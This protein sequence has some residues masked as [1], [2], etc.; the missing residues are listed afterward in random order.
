MTVWLTHYHIQ[1]GDIMRHIELLMTTYDH[2]R[3]SIY[4]RI[5]VKLI[6]QLPLTRSERDILQSM[7]EGCPLDRLTDTL[8]YQ[9]FQDWLNN[10]EVI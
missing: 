3:N 5:I 10:I 7:V 9:D 2:D 6:A 1:Q 8:E 4:R